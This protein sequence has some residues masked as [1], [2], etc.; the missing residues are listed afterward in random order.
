MV[1]LQ[2]ALGHKIV[3]LNEL[4][5]KQSLS[6]TELPD[7]DETYCAAVLNAAG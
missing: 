1:S 4:V 6:V 5:R 7:Q 2:D 3:L